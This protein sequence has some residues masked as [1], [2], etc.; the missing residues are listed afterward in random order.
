M[1]TAA[2]RPRSSVS[3]PKAAYSVLSSQCGGP[4]ELGMHAAASQSSLCHICVNRSSPAGYYYGAPTSGSSDTWVLHLEGGGACFSEETCAQRAKTRLGSSKQWTATVS[5]PAPALSHDCGKNPDFCTAHHV[6]VPYCSGDVHSGQRN[7][8]AGT[9][10]GFVFQGHNN[11]AAVI[12][13]L[14]ED[15]GTGPALRAAKHF[16]LTGSSAG[17]FGTFVNVDYVAS[18]LPW[19][20]NFRGSPAA[21]WFFPGDAPDNPSQPW[22]IPSDWPHWS[23][24]QVGGNPDVRNGS[25]ALLWMTRLH[26][27]CSAANPPLRCW[28]VGEMYPYIESPLFVQQNMYDTN[29]LEVQLL[30]PSNIT[31]DV[32]GYVRYFGYAMRNSTRDVLAKK[33]DGLFLASCLEHGGGLQPGGSTQSGGLNVTIM[34]GDWFFG[35]GAVSH[36]QIDDCSGASDPDLPCNPTCNNLQ[37]H[38][39]GCEAALQGACTDAIKAGDAQCLKCAQNHR[40]ILAGAGCTVQEV[41]KLCKAGGAQLD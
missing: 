26:P 9:V 1:A 13:D 19:V 25:V 33:G 30:M 21:G 34:L 3:Y 2:C 17:G 15:A 11:L 37:P 5:D 18:R 31:D 32:E 27:R 12:D 29:Q 8:S 38:G 39:N 6:Y 36:V 7:A 10:W 40:A 35:R 14:L 41:E 20:T 4:V 16:L 23:V 28:S 22:Q 24:G